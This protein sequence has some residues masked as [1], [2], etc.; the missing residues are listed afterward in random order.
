MKEGPAGNDI[1]LTNVPNI[2]LVYRDEILTTEKELVGAMASS[3]M[4][5]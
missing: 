4:L 5:N 3:S 2:R 1:Q